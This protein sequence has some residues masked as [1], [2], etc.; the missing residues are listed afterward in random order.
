M[1]GVS[2]SFLTVG[3]V[4]TYVKQVFECEEMLHNITVLGEVSNLKIVG[5]YLYFNLKDKDGVLPCVCFGLQKTEI[6]KDGD[7]VFVNGSISFYPKGGKISF[8]VSKIFYAGIGELM[9]FYQQ[10]KEKLER[11]GL[12]DIKHKKPIPKFPKKVCVVTSKTGAVIR[13]IVKTIRN[14]NKEIDISLIDVHVQGDGAVLEIVN[15]LKLADKIGADVVILA[16][17]GGSW[18]DLLPFCNESVA[19]QVFEMNTPII[20]AVGHETDTTLVDYVSDMRV[21]TPTAAGELISYSRRE[22]I[23]YVLSKL[24]YISNMTERKLKDREFRLNNANS[25]V[26]AKAEGCFEKAQGRL[27]LLLHKT[28]SAMQNNFAEKDRRLSIL[29]ERIN[30]S[31]PINVLKKG[32]FKVS[33]DNKSITEKSM[34][35]VGDEI[36]VSSIEFSLKATVNEVLSSEE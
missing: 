19:R 31:N 36:K 14:K 30:L 20:S 29:L 35:K 12:F 13:D 33:I 2:E 21:A 22:Q 24:K 16:R 17:G 23:D 7:R 32:L 34:V 9:L 28:Q 11:E 6:P 3:L 15:G 5:G 26:Y 18:E 8:I 27:N 10:T 25:Y 1:D 4:T